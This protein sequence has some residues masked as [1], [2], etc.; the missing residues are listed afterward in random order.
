MK[1]LFF[2]VEC[3]NCFNG[4][5]KICEFGYALTDEHF[6]I[7]KSDEIPMSPGTD[8]DCRFNLRNKHGEKEIELAYDEDY[9]LS[10]P[11]FP[12]YYEYIKS[13]M[14]DKETVCFA[15]SMSNDIM[16]LFSTCKRYNLAPIN[17]TCF[18]V[19]MIVSRLMNV[20]EAINLEKA[21]KMFVGE[22]YKK[23]ITAHLSRDD[24]KMEM[25]ILREVIVK[26]K[27]DP[28]FFLGTINF[29]KTNSL[30]YAA[31]IEEKSRRKEIARDTNAY[32]NSKC[33]SDREL[34]KEKYL[35]KRVCFSR[36]V[37]TRVSNFIDDIDVLLENGYVLTRHLYNADI[38]VVVAKPGRKPE[39]QE[40][41]KTRFN[42]IILTYKEVGSYITKK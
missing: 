20:K 26:R 21:C 6:N 37:F 39:I 5:G 25:M 1:F 3:S 23:E 17:Y 19:Q 31:K 9:Y 15:Y 13:M 16:H 12:K 11:E 14:E 30:V 18:D 41:I 38:F 29:C 28:V 36:D 42:G 8:E 27:A 22:S 40:K 34:S 4:R 33:K 24:A 35:G 10:C 32:Y 2:D 7:I